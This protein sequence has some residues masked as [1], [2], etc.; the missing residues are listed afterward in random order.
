MREL[1]RVREHG[2]RDNVMGVLPIDLAR[3][4]DTGNLGKRRSP[5]GAGDHSGGEPVVE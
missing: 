3:K 2:P 5:V 4:R 1:E